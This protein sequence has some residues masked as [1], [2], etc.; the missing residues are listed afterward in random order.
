[1][2]IKEEFLQPTLDIFNSYNSHLQ[3]THEVEVK[4]SLNFLD[5]T[6]IKNSGRI[7]TNGFHKKTSSGRILNFHS[8]HSI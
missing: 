2:C 7:I 3:F 1:M 8:N 4:N 6:L 5:L